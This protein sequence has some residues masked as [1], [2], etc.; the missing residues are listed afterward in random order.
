MVDYVTPEDIEAF[1]GN[2]EE[3][4]MAAKKG[5]EKHFKKTGSIPQNCPDMAGVVEGWGYFSTRK[6]FKNAAEIIQKG[7]EYFQWCLDTGHTPVDM[8][9]KKQLGFTPQSF[10]SYAARHP[11]FRQ[12]LNYLLSLC[13]IPLVEALTLTGTNTAGL[14]LVLTNAAY[15]WEPEDNASETP[16]E[17]VMI[18]RQRQEIISNN[19]T[20]LEVNPEGK[21]GA[22][23][24]K[25][26]Q[27]VGKRLKPKDEDGKLDATAE[28]DLSHVTFPESQNDTEHSD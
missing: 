19:R 15:V 22:E 8:G 21:T 14:K 26:M 11:E 24:W 16:L 7:A 13:Y 5:A 3:A 9:L 6:K 17:S 20:S 27:E 25:E 1:G 23:L 10:R 2:A 18:D 4:V 12:A 28:D